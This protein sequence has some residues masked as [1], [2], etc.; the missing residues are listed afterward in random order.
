MKRMAAAI[1][2]LS[3]LAA[4]S[5]PGLQSVTGIRHW[6][7]GEVT[8]VAIEVSGNFEFATDRLHNP[9]RVYYDILS[10]RPRIEE[11]RAYSEQIDDKLLTRIRVAE[12]KPGVT[13][14]V[15]DLNGLVDASSS[16]LS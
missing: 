12:T 3:W 8:R 4:Q 1:L 10:A 16:Q 7:V 2:S 6:P 13:R 11:K 15:L 5:P 14:V 9:E